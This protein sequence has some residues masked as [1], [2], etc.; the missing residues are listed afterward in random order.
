MERA[1]A[2]LRQNGV[3]ALQSFASLTHY[4]LPFPASCG[5]PCDIDCK[6]SAQPFPR[7]QFL[8]NGCIRS[9]VTE[10]DQTT[11]VALESAYRWH[12]N[13]KSRPTEAERPM[14]RSRRGGSLLAP[15]SGGFHP[16][17]RPASKSRG[18]GAGCAQPPA[19][20]TRPKTA[21]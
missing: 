13:G 18:P 19:L 20:A 11:W 3:A 5:E 10:C 21:T 17:P 8:A 9:M 12:R 6:F 4:A 14:S 2:S 7:F 15:T 1:P 16:D